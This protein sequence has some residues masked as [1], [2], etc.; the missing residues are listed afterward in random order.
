MVC[1]FLLFENFSFYFSSNLI[2]RTVIHLLIHK[3]GKISTCQHPCQFDLMIK[4]ESIQNQK[5]NLLLVSLQ[6]FQVNLMWWNFHHP[7]FAYQSFSILVFPIVSSLYRLFLCLNDW[8]SY[9][10]FNRNNNNVVDSRS[11]Y[12][13]MT[14]VCYFI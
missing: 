8:L 13:W 11:Q 9:Y 6:N 3:F 1:K 12:L 4:S 14:I 5:I 10:G 7:L 2:C